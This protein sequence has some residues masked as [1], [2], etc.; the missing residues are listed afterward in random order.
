PMSVTLLATG[1]EGARVVVRKASV[2][3]AFDDTFRRD[4][5]HIKALRS[6]TVNV[7]EIS[8]VIS[9]IVMD[10]VEHIEKCLTPSIEPIHRMQVLVSCIASKRH[11]V[12]RLPD[13]YPMPEQAAEALIG[14]LDGRE[15]GAQWPLPTVG[16]IGEVD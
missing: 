1:E 12:G 2:V 15:R 7:D 14:Y 16:G 6:H 9:F 3:I 13:G 10:S 4:E 5:K 11:S 8:P